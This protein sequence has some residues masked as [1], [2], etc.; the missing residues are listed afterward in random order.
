MTKFLS[1]TFGLTFACT[2]IHL[3]IVKLEEAIQSTTF[4][5]EQQKAGLYLM[6]TTYQ[7]KVHMSALM[8]EFD[9]TAEQ[10]NVLRIL[11]GK[12][13]QSM[14]VKDIASRMIERSS[15]VPRIADRLVAK[16]LVKRY[17]SETDKRETSILLTAKGLA[18]VESS[19]EKVNEQAKSML[20]ISDEE[21]Q[22]LNL[23]LEKINTDSFTTTKKK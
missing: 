21:A 5:S 11:K 14:C 23:L 2:Y 17:Q 9:L 3:H 15:N 4:S 18:L 8:K 16:K 19:I 1:Q 7:V 12:H 13:P 10:Y 6:H 22:Q 20:N